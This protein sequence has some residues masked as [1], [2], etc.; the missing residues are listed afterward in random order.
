[1]PT[2]V[3]STWLASHGAVSAANASVAAAAARCAVR[4]AAT[5]TK[6]AAAATGYADNE[7]RSAAELRAVHSPRTC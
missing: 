5:A 6:L 1:M 4:V 3:G 7:A 2:G